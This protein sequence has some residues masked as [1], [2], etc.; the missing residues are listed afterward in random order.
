VLTVLSVD[1]HVPDK[2]R[3]AVAAATSQEV[4]R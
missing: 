4:H 1:R 2:I 3:L